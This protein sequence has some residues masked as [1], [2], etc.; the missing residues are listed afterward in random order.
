MLL[1]QQGQPFY[2]ANENRPENLAGNTARLFLGV[3]LECVQCHEN[4]LP[5]RTARPTGP[6]TSSGEYRAAT[7]AAISACWPC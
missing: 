2:Q 5:L 6:A 3:K 7:C 1:T 4:T